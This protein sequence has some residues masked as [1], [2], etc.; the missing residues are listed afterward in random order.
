MRNRRP[1]PAMVVAII[2][3]TFSLIGNGYAATQLAKNSVGTT[4]L[5][6]DA[7]RSSKVKNGTLSAA[8][9]SAAARA[10]LRGGQGPAGANGAQGAAG[11]T[12]PNGPT[13]PT[14]PTGPL[15]PQGQQGQQG[16]QGLQGLRGPSDIITSSAGC[17]PGFSTG[18]TIV[19]SLTLPAGNYMVLA[20]VAIQHLG[21]ATDT[22]GG[23][24]TLDRTGSTDDF[25]FDYRGAGSDQA[26]HSAQLPVAATG[27]TTVTMRCT[28]S[29]TDGA[30]LLDSQI[31]AISTE[32]LSLQ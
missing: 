26:S 1:S 8:D 3:L 24:C 27:T 21:L 16:Q 10:T 2:A 22:R 31:T 13:G 20:S 30:R 6:K 19:D 17:C 7:V 5:K 23:R 28:S 9:L 15:G 29:V 32:N 12:G 11:P 18:G 4:Q 14:G 25:V